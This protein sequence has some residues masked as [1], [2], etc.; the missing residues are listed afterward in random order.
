MAV[1][2]ILKHLHGNLI[3]TAFGDD[4]IGIFLAGLHKLLMHGLHGIDILV[5]HGFQ[6]SGPFHDIPLDPADQ[7]DIRIR[8]YKHPDV[9]HLAKL[10]VFKDQDSFYDHNL[11]GNDRDRI[12]TPVMN[13][14]IIDRTL[15]RMTCFQFL[16]VLDHQLGIKGI[17]MIIVQTRSL[18]IRHI[19]MSLIIIVMLQ[20]R[21]MFLKL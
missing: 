14:I 21:H 20:D 13:L 4:N 11:A 16:Q 12:L 1:D 19:V 7:A 10:F 9:H 17:G 6:T 3:I 8:I 2:M 18:F 15:D 5:D